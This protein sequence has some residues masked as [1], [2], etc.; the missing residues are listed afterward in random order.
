MEQ[1]GFLL[2]QKSSVERYLW[3]LA[4][5]EMSHGRLFF[6]RVSL[7]CRFSRDTKSKAAFFGKSPKTRPPLVTRCTR[8]PSGERCRRRCEG[9]VSRRPPRSICARSR[10]ENLTFVEFRFWTEM[11]VFGV[12]WPILVVNKKVSKPSNLHPTN[13]NYQ[14][15]SAH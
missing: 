5:V 3:F 9:L 7:V 11:L 14:A 10:R 15:G 6:L 2:A 8:C 1:T 4:K 12:W 13:L